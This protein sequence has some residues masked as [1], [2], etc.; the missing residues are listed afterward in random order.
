MRT[1][2]WFWLSWPSSLAGVAQM[3][4]QPPCKRQVSGSIPLTGSPKLPTSPL[5]ACGNAGTSD[6]HDAGAPRDLEVPHKI[7]TTCPGKLS[8][9]A[10]RARAGGPPRNQILAS[11]TE[12]A[13]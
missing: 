3:A 10:G 1:S 4:E 9:P 13:A 7:P 5:T 2:A 12:R 11:G 6:L 8:R